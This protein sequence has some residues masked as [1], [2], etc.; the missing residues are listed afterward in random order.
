MHTH[1]CLFIDHKV[2]TILCM[3]NARA[4][5]DVLLVFSWHGID[6]IKKL[7]LCLFGWHRCNFWIKKFTFIPSQKNTR[8]TPEDA[9]AFLIMYYRNELI[10]VEYSLFWSHIMQCLTWWWSPL[11]WK[12]ETYHIFI[13]VFGTNS[14]ASP[15]KLQCHP[16]ILVVIPWNKYTWPGLKQIRPN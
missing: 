11:K 10:H 16:N 2:E 3:R 4:S 1:W 15:K 12:T 13:L 8:K 5:S 6:V 7:Y 14:I 9:L